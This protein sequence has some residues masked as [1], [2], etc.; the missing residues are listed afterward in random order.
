MED[1]VE[2]KDQRQRMGQD[3]G[4]TQRGREGALR[5][6]GAVCPNALSALAFVVFLCR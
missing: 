1:R 6:R 5:D 2:G 4:A 3:A